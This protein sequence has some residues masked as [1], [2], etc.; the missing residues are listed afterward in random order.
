MSQNVTLPGNDFGGPVARW[1]PRTGDALRGPIRAHRHRPPM[2]IARGI[3]ATG[4][5]FFQERGMNRRKLHHTC[6]GF[7]SPHAVNTGG[8]MLEILPRDC[9][10]CH[11]GGRPARLA[12]ERA[13]SATRYSVM[14]S[15]MAVLGRVI[16]EPS[17]YR[18]TETATPNSADC[19]LSHAAHH[20][21]RAARVGVTG[22]HPIPVPQVACPCVELN[23][24]GHFSFPNYASRVKKAEP[25]R[26]PLAGASS[27]FLPCR[28]LVGS[29]S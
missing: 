19:T 9:H 23:V 27:D 6:I 20:G 5:W 14:R 3:H 4:P 12:G 21:T 22:P 8:Q 25:I 16:P 7:M 1:D 2:C 29:T 11:F 18:C 28:H 24:T 13:R 17:G 10:F 26:R 15:D